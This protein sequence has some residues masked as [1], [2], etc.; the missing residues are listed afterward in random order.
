MAAGRWIETD[1]GENY[2]TL[3]V[4]AMLCGVAAGSAQEHRHGGAGS[5]QFPVSCSAPA[6]DTFQHGVAL[7]HSFWYGEAEK[8]FR[9]AAVLDPACAMAWWGVAM[10]RYHPL[11]AAPARAD[12]EAGSAA[13]EKAKSA[14]ARTPRE[15]DYIR[16]V[17]A[18]YRNWETAAHKNRA[19]AWS[20]AMRQLATQYP[21]D[22]EASIFY[23]LSL[24]ATSPAD[25]KEYR[26]QK[27]AAEILNRILPEQP[28]HPGIF[29]YLIH[30]YDSP[31]LAGMAL[32]AAR[33]Y[34][35]VA[36]AGVWNSRTLART[37]P[38]RIGVRRRSNPVTIGPRLPQSCR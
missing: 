4:A 8:T 23:A 7:L 29:H 19:A 3:L 38:S 9:Q 11:W 22:R 5:V 24:I 25:D 35:K 14:R 36:P 30:S 6:K 1:G 13:V 18:F 20:R 31:Q 15:A 32:T 37:W 21:E 17:E 2:K 28:D 16:A 27:R 12:L 34:A 33:Q 10:S 26:N